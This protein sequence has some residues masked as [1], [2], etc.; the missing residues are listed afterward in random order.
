MLFSRPPAE[1]L[2][3][4]SSIVVGAIAQSDGQW[5][6]SPFSPP[7]IPLAV[8]SPY[9]NSWLPQGSNASSANEAW[10][11]FWNE[12]GQSDG[13]STASFNCSEL[14]S[15]LQKAQGRL[16]QGITELYA[17]VNVDGTS[18]RLLGAAE[19]PNVQAAQQL[20]VDITATRTSFLFKA[21]PMEIN[22][23]FLSPIDVSNFMTNE[24]FFIVL[25]WSN[26]E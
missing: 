2:L 11:T 18:Y 20:A 5:T 23:T 14:V 6:T 19:V 22:A 21:G 13:I 16:L 24:T 1:V 17:G 26:D 7:A 9:L 10:A 3:T 12:V 25:T 15:L 4:I 8:K